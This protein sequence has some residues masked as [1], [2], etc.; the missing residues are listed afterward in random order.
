[1]KVN[2]LYE[3]NACL[4]KRVDFVFLCHRNAGKFDLQHQSCCHFSEIL[5]PAAHFCNEITN[6]ESILQYMHFCPD[7]HSVT[8]LCTQ[9]HLRMYFSVSVENRA[10][11]IGLT[12]LCRS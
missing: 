1:M 8:A 5:I 2:E 12:A 4:A 9:L 7:Q 10:F 6:F 11:G 3:R